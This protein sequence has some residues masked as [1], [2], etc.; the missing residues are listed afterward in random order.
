MAEEL[1]RSAPLGVVLRSLF[2][3]LLSIYRPSTGA[4]GCLALAAWFEASSAGM[5]IKDEILHARRRLEQALLHRIE[6]ACADS[7]LQAGVSPATALRLVIATLDMVAIQSRGDLRTESIASNA[8][9][10][11]ALI[12]AA[13]PTA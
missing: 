6:L 11:V 1:G 12:C 8:D 2:R 10:L 13:S 5:I 9:T 7:D 3:R 4:K